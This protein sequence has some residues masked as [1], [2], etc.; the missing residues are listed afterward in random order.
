M[1]C[2]CIYTQDNAFGDK[3]GCFLREA[4]CFPSDNMEYSMKPTLNCMVDNIKLIWE[5]AD[6]K[7]AGSVVAAL[8]FMPSSTMSIDFTRPCHSYTISACRKKAQVEK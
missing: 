2:I 8:G 5:L 1:Y 6:E 3:A 7:N 4:F